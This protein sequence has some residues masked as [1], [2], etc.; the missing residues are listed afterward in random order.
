MPHIIILDDWEALTE[1]LQ[2]YA[3]QIHDNMAT[4]D[5]ERA[6]EAHGLL[7]SVESFITQVDNNHRTEL[8]NQIGA[9]E[10][11]LGI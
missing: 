6:E 11:F 10:S 2:G 1:Q 9:L 5:K 7:Q 4:Y 3:E 8:E